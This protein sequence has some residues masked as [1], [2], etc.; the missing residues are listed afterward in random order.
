MGE[1]LVFKTSSWSLGTGVEKADFQEVK[2]ELR[3]EIHL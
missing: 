1:T 3:A 2:T